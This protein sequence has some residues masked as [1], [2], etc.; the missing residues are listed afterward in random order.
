MAS[1][2]FR[3]LMFALAPAFRSVDCIAECRWWVHFGNEEH[4]SLRTWISENCEEFREM[5]IVRTPN[6]LEQ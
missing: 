3:E 4:T 2:S 5:Q 6:M 1:S